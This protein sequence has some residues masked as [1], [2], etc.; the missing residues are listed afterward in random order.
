MVEP[1]FREGV[2][3]QI[4]PGSFGDAIGDLPGLTSKPEYVERLGIESIRLNPI[5]PWPNVG[6]GYDLAD[7][8]RY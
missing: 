6:W 1:W 8:T 3:Y 7:H 4:Q 2:L 5:H